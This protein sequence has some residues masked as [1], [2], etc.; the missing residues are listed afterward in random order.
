MTNQTNPE[1]E[2]LTSPTV[3]Q[4]EEI[5]V[6]TNNNELDSS[7]EG[8]EEYEDLLEQEFG[9][10]TEDSS[11]D[12]ELEEAEFEGK[13]YKLPKQIKGALLR[14]SDYTKKTQ[15]IAELRKATEVQK[16][17]VQKMDEERRRNFEAYA[18]VHNL[19]A[20]LEQAYK[21]IDWDRLYEEDPTNA[22]K[23]EREMRVLEGRRNQRLNEIRQK[24]TELASKQQQETAKLEEETK[25]SISQ[26]I[27]NW[28]SE[29]ESK[30][31]QYAKK[32]GVPEETFRH[33]TKTDAVAIKV[34]HDAYAYNQLKEKVL[35]RKPAKVADLEPVTS[36]KPRVKNSSNFSFEPSDKDSMDEWVKKRNAQL[37]QRKQK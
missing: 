37:A 10:E 29:L 3:N 30:L 6:K 5:K 31:L 4:T 22:T 12:E 11:T 16:E 2:V 26:N 13:K 25:S 8:Q 14:Q 23:L 34:L 20:Q 19:N 36:L 7:Q 27:K 33:A 32:V 24:E 21:S 15:E 28:N 35:S 9:E 18:E 17:V 1:T